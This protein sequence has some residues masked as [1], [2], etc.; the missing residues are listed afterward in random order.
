[1]CLVRAHRLA[2]ASSAPWC[3]YDVPRERHPV[4]A[5]SLKRSSAL[6]G[7]VAPRERREL[8]STTSVL[9]PSLGGR[10]DLAQDPGV[11]RATR[12]RRAVAA[13][14]AAPA[15]SSTDC[16]P[17]PG[18]SARSSCRAGASKVGRLD[19]SLSTWSGSAACDQLPQAARELSALLAV[20][21]ERGRRQRLQARR[22]P[23]SVDAGRR[24]AAPSR[25]ARS[26]DSSSRRSCA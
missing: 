2:R 13:R 8:R 6:V 1:M 7:I 21:G 14:R 25:R 18:A 17:G 22:G 11:G 4:A 3:S 16:S 26:S 12:G 9:Q 10:A 5:R 20:G 19:R 15:T 24:R 23:S